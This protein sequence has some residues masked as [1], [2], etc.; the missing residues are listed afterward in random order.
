MWG[1]KP[2][3]DT[4][5]LDYNAVRYWKRKTLFVTYSALHCTLAVLTLEVLPLSVIR[6]AAWPLQTC[7]HFKCLLT[8]VRQDRSEN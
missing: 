3:M 8:E 7:A 2:A 4:K 6:K 5:I 1:N